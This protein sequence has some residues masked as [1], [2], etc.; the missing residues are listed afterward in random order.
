MIILNAVSVVL[1]SHNLTNLGIFYSKEIHAA[2]K[3]FFYIKSISE[4]KINY[5]KL[6]LLS[7]YLK[8]I[9]ILFVSFNYKTLT[10]YHFK[11]V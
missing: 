3:F 8:P 6:I 9:T 11:T 1:L 5:K 10:L 7:V 4:K 2:E